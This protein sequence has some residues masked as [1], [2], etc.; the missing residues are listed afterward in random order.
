MSESSP[1]LPRVGRLGLARTAA[2][3]AAAWALL[4]LFCWIGTQ[5]GAAQ[6]H[7][8]VSL[9]TAQPVATPAALAEGLCWSLVFGAGL[10]LLAAFF[11]NLFEGFDRR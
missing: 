3:G 11:F 6:S 1:R 4:F 9:F 5:L 10:G 7:M 8:F 2:A